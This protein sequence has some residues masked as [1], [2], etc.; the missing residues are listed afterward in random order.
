MQ[1]PFNIQAKIVKLNAAKIELPKSLAEVGQTYFQQNFQKSQWNGNAWAQRKA[2][3]YA[4]K[5]RGKHLLVKTGNLRR[6]LQNTIISYDWKKI[7]WGI[8]G[9]DY[10]K[11]LN[12]G[13]S[14]MPQ[15]QFIGINEELKAKIKKKIES[16]FNKIMN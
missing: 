6:A 3:Y 1:N 10:A 2:G 5:M 8:K 9:V 4:N 12:N 14:F 7:T 13:T 16:E 11:Y 15:R